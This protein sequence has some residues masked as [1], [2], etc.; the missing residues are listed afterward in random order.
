MS[1]EEQQMTGTFTLSGESFRLSL[2]FHVFESDIACPANAVISVCV[3]GGGFSGCAEMDI[4]IKDIA[5]FCGDL[6]RIYDSLAGEARIQEPFGERQYILFSG[7]RRG[8][9]MISGMLT[10]GGAGGCR[11]ELRFENCIDQTSLPCFLGGLTEFARRAG[12]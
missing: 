4:D 7:D 10:S 5:G 11:Q 12:V 8:H 3:S 2:V 1:K 9:V 6:Q